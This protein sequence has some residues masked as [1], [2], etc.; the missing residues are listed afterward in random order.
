MN[1]I[2]E[3]L[4]FIAVENKKKPKKNWFYTKKNNIIKFKISLVIKLNH[5]IVFL[6][7]FN[8]VY[9]FFK[10]NL[11]ELRLGSMLQRYF[12]FYYPVFFLIKPKKNFADC[13]QFIKSKKINDSKT[14]LKKF[15]LWL[16]NKYWKFEKNS[17]VHENERY[18]S[19][20]Y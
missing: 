9:N 4:I 14:A 11:V 10:K 13:K 19:D 12:E 20:K 2:K 3:Y 5:L 1:P 16:Q 8:E 7:F 18:N 15:V 17:F 6:F